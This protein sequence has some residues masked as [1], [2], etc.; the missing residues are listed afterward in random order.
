MRD[1]ADVAGVAVS[2]VSRALANPGRV[3][4]ATLKQIS[5][6]ARKLGY[7]PNAAA[8]SLRSGKTRVILIVL[9]GRLTYGASQIIPHALAGIDAELSQ[10]GYHI[11]I[12]NLDRLAGTDRHIVDLASGGAVDGVIILS[13]S[14]PRVGKRSVLDGGL[15]VVAMFQD[16]SAEGVPSVLTNERAM[17]RQLTS[18]LYAQGHRAFYYVSG[19][20]GNYHE[21]QRLGGIREALAGHGLAPDSLRHSAGRIA[22]QQGF[23]I[24]TDAARDFLALPDRPSA[25]MCCS[26]DAALAFMRVLID[27]GV[28]IPDEVSVAGFDGAAIGTIFSPSL[29][30][31]EQPAIRMGAQAAS[32]LLALLNNAAVP[33]V[34]VL[35]STFIPRASTAPF[36]EGPST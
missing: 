33:A 22:Y 19:P 13:S 29:T 4:D 28:A 32:L 17:M 21:E 24:G 34:T 18:D 16:L 25:V 36:P 5:E 23:E 6:A 1:V 10:H 8:R 12:A 27:A 7:T 31:I 20:A 9:P 35:D 30:T 15:P 14:V 3:S 11:L 26:D 2:T